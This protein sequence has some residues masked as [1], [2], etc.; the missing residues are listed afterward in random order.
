MASPEPAEAV[1]APGAAR[2]AVFRSTPASSASGSEA[3]SA[4]S[5]PAKVTASASGRSR[6]PPHTGHT[7][8]SRWRCTRRRVAGLF[9]SENARITYRRALMNFPSYGRWIRPASRTGCTVTTGC[10]SVNSSQSR[11]AC[12]NSRHGRSMS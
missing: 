10:S 3:S 2:P 9:D 6:L 4:M 7:A 1:A 11:S 5:R 8:L 12:G